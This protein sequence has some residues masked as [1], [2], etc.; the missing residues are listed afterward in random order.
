MNL[1]DIITYRENAGKE[2][3][4]NSN[5]KDYNEYNNFETLEDLKNRQKI[6]IKSREVEDNDDKNNSSNYSYTRSN[7]IEKELENKIEQNNINNKENIVDNNLNKD[8]DI[9]GEGDIIDK[10]IRKIRNKQDINLTQKVQKKTLSNLDE[11]LRLG[12]KQLE[13]IQTKKNQKVISNNQKNIEI[14]KKF[15]SFFDLNSFNKQNYNISHYKKGSYFSYKNIKILKPI[16]YFHSE[17]KNN[18]DYNHKQKK[19]NKY[20]LSSIDGKVIID[21]ERKNP[22]DNLDNLLKG[23]REPI[24]NEF[25]NNL[26]RQRSFSLDNKRIYEKNQNFLDFGIRKVDYYNKNYF[27]E[28]INRIDNLLFS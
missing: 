18:I 1:Q 12:L 21:G 6:N 5:N 28:E 20:Y 4:F 23:I 3:E 9:I 19:Q 7:R 24:R 16:I 15:K 11:E 10:L 26:K 22:Y 14:G 17:R 25:K 8:K 2:S 13:K 27:L